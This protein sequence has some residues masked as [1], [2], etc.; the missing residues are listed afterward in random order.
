M[1]TTD[2]DVGETY[3]YTLVSGSGDS[4]NGSFSIFGDELRS[5]E[6]FDFETQTSYS[7]RIRT[8]DG[9]GG[10]REEEWTIDINDVSEAP[11]ALEINASA[12]DEKNSI[13]DV[14]GNFTTTDEDAGETY[15]YTL[16][17]GAGDARL[18]FP[19]TSL[20]QAVY[21]TL[22]AKTPTSSALK[23]MMEMVDYLRK[24]L[25]SL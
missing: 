20:E 24:H 11:T 9:F 2:Q 21:L 19:V 5:G 23:P 17:S 7:V 22:K 6:V 16:A 13:N 3:T 4:G 1:T 15:T 25:P 14:I 18:I 10:I 12:I 8:D